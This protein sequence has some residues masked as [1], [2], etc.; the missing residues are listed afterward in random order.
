MV[1]RMR[2]RPSC[3]TGCVGFWGVGEEGVPGPQGADAWPG[4]CAGQTGRWKA[5]RNGA[6]AWPVGGCTQSPTARADKG[7]GGKRG[8]PPRAGTRDSATAVEAAW[9]LP[10]RQAGSQGEAG[11]QPR[12]VETQRQGDTGCPAPV[13]RPQSG[14][15]QVGCPLNVVPPHDR[16][17]SATQRDEA[18]TAHSSREPR[19]VLRENV[20]FHSHNRCSKGG[21]GLRG[22]AAGGGPGRWPLPL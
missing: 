5:E 8:P 14:N 20:H 3:K 16:N 10:T 2:P 13:T 21:R 9:Q 22:G 18:P 11:Q 17:C 1:V 7:R 4:V 19:P 12:S 15:R 6:W